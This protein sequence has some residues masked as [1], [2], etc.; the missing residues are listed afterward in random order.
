MKHEAHTLVSMVY[1]LLCIQQ[2]TKECINAR[3]IMDVVLVLFAL[4]NCA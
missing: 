1:T 4:I 2:P 3:K